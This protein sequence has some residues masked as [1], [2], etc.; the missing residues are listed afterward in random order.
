M[1]LG[2]SKPSTLN[3]SPQPCDC[4]SICTYMYTHDGNISSSKTCP[5]YIV[6]YIY[7]YRRMSM[8]MLRYVRAS[9]A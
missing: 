8:Y 9:R 7:I 2:E 5:A 3:L 6:A 1:R 4:I